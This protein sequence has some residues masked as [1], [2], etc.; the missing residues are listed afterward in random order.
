M[1]ILDEYHAIKGNNDVVTI[2]EIIAWAGRNPSSRWH[3]SL[4]WNNSIAGQRWRE[5]QVRSL[6][7]MLMDLTTAG[8]R[9]P[10]QQT[11][12]PKD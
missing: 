12:W 4:E 5:D 10:S 11:R 2:N 3:K 7:A 8:V 6:L 1:S 9:L